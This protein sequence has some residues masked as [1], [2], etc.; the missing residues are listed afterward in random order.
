[1]FHC[2]TVVNCVVHTQM[3]AGVDEGFRDLDLKFHHCVCMCIVYVFQ[4]SASVDEGLRHRARC[5]HTA[6]HLLQA[7]LKTVLG[8]HITQQGSLVTVS[9]CLPPAP[10]SRPS[11]MQCSVCYLSFP[12][13]LC[14]YAG[15][16]SLASRGGGGAK[17]WGGG[18][19]LE[20]GPPGPMVAWQ[21]G[22]NILGRG[23]GFQW[24]PI[25]TLIRLHR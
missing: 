11:T 13:V 18:G 17:I 23:W 3:T 24:G 5:N 19:G 6:T 1:M 10:H 2:I 20:G 16:K 25:G 7:A 9:P 21:R 14:V 15:Y 12:Y 22:G 4:M 8:E